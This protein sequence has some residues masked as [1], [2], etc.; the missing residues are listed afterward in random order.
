MFSFVHSEW[1]CP[2]TSIRLSD[3]YRPHDI[4]SVTV[5]SQH[6]GARR[7]SH[8]VG[9]CA[10]RLLHASHRARIHSRGPDERYARHA[11]PNSHDARR[12]EA[13]RASKYE[14]TEDVQGKAARY[15]VSALSAPR[16][17]AGLARSQSPLGTSPGTV[18]PMARLAPT[19]VRSASAVAAAKPVHSF[20]A[21]AQLKQ[22][23]W[24]GTFCGNR[25]GWRR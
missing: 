11:T 6:T 7:C 16:V 10:H 25:C 5:S 21:C 15:L 1:I 2:L 13:H 3:I 14:K 23:T 12:R 18:K 24:P 8:V 17:S 4:H 9:S 19:H 22:C 20:H